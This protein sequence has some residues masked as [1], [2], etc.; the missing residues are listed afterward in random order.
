MG[1][2]EASGQVHVPGALPPKKEPPVSLVGA[3]SR[4][5]RNDDEKSPFT[6]PAGKWTPTVQPVAQLLHLLSY[7]SSMHRRE[8][9]KDKVV[10]VLN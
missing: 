1:Q 10:L 4:S 9:G 5:G 7:H 6:A 3:Q 8:A 2:T